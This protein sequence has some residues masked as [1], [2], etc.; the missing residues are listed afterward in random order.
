M[1]EQLKFEK[2]KHYRTTDD[3]KLLCT[4]AF[5][6]GDG[7]FINE[8]RDT[9]AYHLKDSPE[10]VAEWREP[11]QWT[12]YIY[13]REGKTCVPLFVGPAH[14]AATLTLLARVPATE[15]EGLE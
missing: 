10:I 9:W 5:S 15:G 6:S 12:V 11:R 7:L 14:V 8:E 1:T 4:W 13:E 3:R 2:G